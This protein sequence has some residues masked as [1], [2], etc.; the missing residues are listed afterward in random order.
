MINTQNTNPS[1]PVYKESQFISFSMGTE[2]EETGYHGV[3]DESKDVEARVGVLKNG[4]EAALANP[5]VHKNEDCLKIFMLPEFFFRGTK[6]AYSMDVAS[7]LS[8]K[9]RDLVKSPRFKDWLFVFGTTM[10]YSEMKQDQVVQFETYN[11][12]FIQKGH[13]DEKDSWIILKEHKSPVDFIHQ[14]YDRSL[15]GRKLDFRNTRYLPKLNKHATTKELKDFNYDGKTIFDIGGIRIGVEICLDHIRQRIH[16]SALLEKPMDFLLIPS[17]G[18]IRPRRNNLL[19]DQGYTFIC[20]GLKNGYS[21]MVDKNR[22]S[23]PPLD[24]KII[25]LPKYQGDQK[26]FHTNQ[27]CLTIYPS[28]NSTLNP[29]LKN[30]SDKKINCHEI[31]M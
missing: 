15:Q 31:G 30:L 9:L 17:C 5:F 3:C 25:E 10:G 28:T 19:N 8:E 22:N 29:N 2:N 20:D 7:S 23:T 26:L 11:F 4:L 24:S 6:G 16:R 12:S 13:G 14:E 21:M 18:V 27:A 1:N